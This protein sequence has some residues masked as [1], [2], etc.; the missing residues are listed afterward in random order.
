MKVFF[1]NEC[2]TAFAQSF[3]DVRHGEAV[4]FLIELALTLVL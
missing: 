3:L 1:V 2:F 4:Q